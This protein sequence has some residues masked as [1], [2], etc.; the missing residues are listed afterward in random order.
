MLAQRER[1]PVRAWA[2]REVVRSVEVLRVLRAY[3]P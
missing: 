3:Y 2:L 1:A